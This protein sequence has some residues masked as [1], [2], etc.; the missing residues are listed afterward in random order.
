MKHAKTKEKKMSS[1]CL[2]FLKMIFIFVLK[3]NKMT[4][5]IKNIYVLFFFLK[6]MKEYKKY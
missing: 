6:N 3:N 1:F 2:P 4:E 5:N